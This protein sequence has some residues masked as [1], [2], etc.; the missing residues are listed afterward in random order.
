MAVFHNACIFLNFTC[1]YFKE[2]GFSTSI[3]AKEE[4]F[5]ASLKVKADIF[6]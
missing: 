3:G 2:C 6:E 1:Q 4:S 5:F